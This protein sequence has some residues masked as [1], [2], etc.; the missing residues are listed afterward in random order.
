MFYCSVWGGK[1]VSDQQ[2]RKSNISSLSTEINI[3][4]INKYK[5]KINK[6]VDI[7]VEFLQVGNH[8][9]LQKTHLGYVLKR[10]E[11]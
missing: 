7:V 10:D 4:Q 11:T 6:R 3:K 2:G 5:R 9:L 8:P 1:I